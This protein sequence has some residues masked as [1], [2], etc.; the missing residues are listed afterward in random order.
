MAIQLV[1]GKKFYVRDGKDQY[2]VTVRR[3]SLP[4]Y[5]WSMDTGPDWLVSEVWMDDGT[6]YHDDCGFNIVGE[7]K[8]TSAVDKL[9]NGVE[10]MYFPVV[11]GSTYRT[12]GA[13]RMYEAESKAAYLDF[14][15]DLQ[16]NRDKLG[17]IR[18]DSRSSNKFAKM[19]F[20]EINTPPDYEPYEEISDGIVKMH[21]SSIDGRGIDWFYCEFDA[22]S[23]A[24]DK[25]TKVDIEFVR[26]DDLPLI[27]IKLK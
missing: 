27:A 22:S 16:N 23:E 14:I 6:A 1:E 13:W 25:F 18:F 4:R 12:G 7:I 10:V 20:P 21:A 15:R 26:W 9:W 2:P 24:F 19:C 8:I 11:E 17:V 5:N 3:N